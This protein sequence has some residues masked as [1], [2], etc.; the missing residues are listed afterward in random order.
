VSWMCFGGDGARVAQAV[1][2]MEMIADTFLS[3]ATP[4]QLALPELLRSRTSCVAAIRERTRENL[5]RVRAACRGSAVSVLHAGG[6]WN[7]VLRLP[8][9]QSDEAWALGLLADAHVLVQPGYFYDFEGPPYCVVSLLPRPDVVE[10]G[11]RRLVRYVDASV[12]VK[13]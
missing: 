12:S 9:T 8:S 1:E 6:G 7:A 5:E 11:A 4:V 10:H 13:P 2:R 3:V